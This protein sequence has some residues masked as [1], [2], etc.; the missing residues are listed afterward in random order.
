MIKRIG[1]KGFI[2]FG[3]IFALIVGALVLFFAFYFIG[4]KM[5]ESKTGQ[6]LVSENTLDIILNP[7]SSFG[8]LGATSSKEITLQRKERT[9]FSCTVDVGFGYDGILSATN[10]GVRMAVKKVY[11]K[12]IFSEDS[13]YSKNLQVISKPFNMPW[14][15]ADLIYLFSRDRD[16]CFVGMRG[17]STEEEFGSGNTGMNI[18][19]FKFVDEKSDCGNSITVCSN[20]ACDIELDFEYSR[21]VKGS[22]EFP[23]IDDSTMYAA[24]FS[25]YDSY[26]CNMKRVAQKI[27]FEIEVYR[28]K[29]RTLGARQCTAVFSMDALDQA[30]SQVISSR[31]SAELTEGM[32]RLRAAADALNVQNMGADCTLY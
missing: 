22:K 25:D 14:R 7:F 12:Y 31:T 11:D 6:G 27:R 20:S 30:A 10:P 15:A 32:N 2:E 3:W 8:S 26:S 21:I 24:I 28:N 29:A 9:N 1:K 23:F 4:T 19:S 16:Y 13:I 17:S 5:S 18:S